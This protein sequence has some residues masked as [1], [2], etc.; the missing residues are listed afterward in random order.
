MMTTSEGQIA[1][2][3]SEWSAT[4]DQL[5]CGRQP[6]V[7]LNA[8]TG[9]E[10]DDLAVAPRLIVLAAGNVPWDQ[11]KHYPNANVLRSIEDPG[12]AWNALTVGAYTSLTEFDKTQYPGQKPIA[13]AGAIAP[14]TTTSMVWKRP[15]PLKPDLLAEGGNGT[16]GPGMHVHVGPESLRLLSTS[17]DFV[18][19]PLTETGDTSAA[20]AIAARLCAELNARYP[21]HWPETIRALV[22]HGARHTPAMRGALS[23]NPS[24]T[25][26]EQFLRT[27]GHGVANP[28]NSFASTARRPTLVVEEVVAP[29]RAEGST[30]RLGE[31]HLHTLPWP[32]EELLALGETEVALRVTLSYFIEPNPARR[33]WHSKYRYQSFG[34][35]FSVK[36]A[37]EDEEHF[38]QRVNKLERDEDSDE[39]FSE[40]DS[41]GWALGARLR[42]RGSIHCDEWRGTAAELALKNQIAVF[43]VGGWWKDW[44]EAGRFNEKGRYALVVSLEVLQDIQVDLY[45]SIEAKIPV[46]VAVDV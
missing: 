36:G 40:A 25:E 5:A 21:N 13:P 19:T 6:L 11:W 12:Q 39:S 4:I 15:W 14:C 35:R 1:G 24:K 27:Y 8:A 44:K 16:I 10:A 32:R 28:D 26:K 23:L 18:A 7:G 3:P 46:T 17:H 45:A 29:Y 31:M 22:V 9:G 42:D 38:R 34:L 37:T 30:V 33:G 43:P 20:A 2:S 41:D